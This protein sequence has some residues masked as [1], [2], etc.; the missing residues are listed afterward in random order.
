MT[1]NRRNMHKLLKTF[2]VQNETD[3]DQTKEDCVTG[4]LYP[5]GGRILSGGETGLA[6]DSEF[7]ELC[8]KGT[9]TS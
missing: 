9:G 2:T 1:W 3:Y 8:G 6:D 4:N 7:G 5:V